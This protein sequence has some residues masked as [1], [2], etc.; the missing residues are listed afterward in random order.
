MGVVGDSAEVSKGVA[1]RARGEDGYDFDGE[2]AI[3]PSRQ[4]VMNDMHEERSSAE[5]RNI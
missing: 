3:S 5:I 4:P 1:M 2:S